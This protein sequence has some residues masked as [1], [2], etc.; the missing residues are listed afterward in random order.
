LILFYFTIGAKE[1]TKTWQLLYLTTPEM[2]Q[3]NCCWHFIC[4]CCSVDIA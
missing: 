3:P 1:K 4:I 2:G